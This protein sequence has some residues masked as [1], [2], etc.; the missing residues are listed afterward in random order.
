MAV[1]LRLGLGLM[2]AAALPGAAA[3]PAA[4][5]PAGAEFSREQ[6]IELVQ[7]RYAARVVRT[8]VIEQDGR[9]LYE[10]RLLSSNGKVWTVRIDPHGG[11]EVPS[12]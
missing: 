6:T 3:T 11:A 9:R 12:P 7:L 4:S 2:C 8:V 5:V 10:F 1:A